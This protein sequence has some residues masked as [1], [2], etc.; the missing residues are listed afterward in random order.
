M[1][2]GTTHGPNAARDADA[3]PGSDASRGGD[4]AWMALAI[5]AARNAPALPFGAVLVDETAG[6]VLASGWNRGAGD[7]TGHGEIDVLQRLARQ[8]ADVPWHV[9]TLYT[10]AEPC[11]MCTAALVWAGVRRVVYGVSIPWLAE[12]GWWQMDLRAEVVLRHAPGRAVALTG[13]V[14]AAECAALFEAAQNET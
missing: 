4:D 12:H 14:C 2:R 13:G 9:L 8:Q 7:P 11:P 6:R 3:A 5:D 10:T 1:S